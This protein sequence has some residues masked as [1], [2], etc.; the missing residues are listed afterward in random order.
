MPPTGSTRVFVGC[1]K[2]PSALPY[3]AGFWA[4]KTAVVTGATGFLG[5]WTIRRLLGHGSN[6]IALVRHDHPESQLALAGFD[7]RVTI[8]RGDVSDSAVVTQLF[9][10]PLHAIFHIAANSDVERAWR[11]P[12]ASISEAMRS[13]L[14][15]AEQI[16]TRQP[17]CAMVVSSSDKAY[18]PQAIPYR[19]D[20]NLAPRHPYEV[21][22]A[23]QDQIARSYGKV[24]DLPITVTRCANYFGGF[25]FNWHRIIPGTIRSLLRGE[26]VVLRSD[27]KFTRDFLY[28]EDAVD[29]QL[30]L[31]ER[32]L[33]DASLHGEAFNF[34]HEVD[35]EVID[36][37]RRL[38]SIAGRKI[39][40]IIGNTAK[41]EIRFMRFSSEKAIKILNWRPRHDFDR[42]L[43]E[44]V[45]WYRDYLETQPKAT[46]G[47]A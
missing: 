24:Y 23:C 41:A 39:E 45:T 20:S 17:R 10:R 26:D 31:A 9:D 14:A 11:E 19:E 32:S 35:I 22:K 15:L 47:T 29:C 42:A 12:E 34:S 43:V 38:I 2:L 28:I 8:V 5:G 37:V 4:G 1:P 13:T 46:T 44:T 6:V 36:I 21:A 3:D 16:R 30:L 7:R 40:P 33:A 18:G 27:G 25:D